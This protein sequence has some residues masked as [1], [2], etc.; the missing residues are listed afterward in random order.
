MLDHRNGQH[1]IGMSTFMFNKGKIREIKISPQRKVNIETEE[2]SCH[3]T[4]ETFN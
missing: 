2:A 1:I 4:E 3:C